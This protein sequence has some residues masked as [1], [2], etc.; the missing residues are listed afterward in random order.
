MTDLT[1]KN[2]ALE[3]EQIESAVENQQNP[4]GKT[5]LLKEFGKIIQPLFNFSG[6][7]RF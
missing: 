4:S 1:E 7:V 3:E 2:T 5:F 6:F